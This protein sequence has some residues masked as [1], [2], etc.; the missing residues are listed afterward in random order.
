MAFSPSTFALM[1]DTL[2][3]TLIRLWTYG[4]RDSR[5]VV[6]SSAYVSGVSQRGV[7]VGDLV[8]VVEWDENNVHQSA[9]T[10]RVSAIIADSATLVYDDNYLQ[11]FSTLANFRAANIS[12]SIETVRVNGALTAGDCPPMTFV[13]KSSQPS[14]QGK[15]QSADGAWWE[16]AR[17]M[18]IDL[19]WFEPTTDDSYSAGDVTLAEA[20]AA[21]RTLYDA[22]SITIEEWLTSNTIA[23]KYWL[24]TAA[25]YGVKATAAPGLVRVFGTIVE[26]GN[27]FL[28]VECAAGLRFRS[29]PVTDR[30]D[31]RPM[32]NI[33]SNVGTALDRPNFEWRG[34][35]FLADGLPYG[36]PAGTP[37]NQGAGGARGG[38]LGF[39]RYRRGYLA[40]CHFK[41]GTSYFDAN[42]TYATPGYV[43]GDQ[44]VTF[45]QCK[46]I[47]MFD[48]HGDGLPDTMVYPRTNEDMDDPEADSAVGVI[49]ILSCS[50]K[51]CHKGVYGK[52]SGGRLIVRDFDAQ[53]CEHAVQA[54][55]DYNPAAA[56]GGT[57][58]QPYDCIISGVRGERIASRVIEVERAQVAAVSDVVVSDWG[59]RT[60]GEA[61]VT[62]GRSYVP[63]VMFTGCQ[64]FG[65]SNMHARLRDWDGG[66]STLHT[67][68]FL[69]GVLIES[70]TAGSGSNTIVSKT[71]ILSNISIEGI[72]IEVTAG[73][74]SEVV[75]TARRG[76][77]ALV[78]VR[79]ASEATVKIDG[80]MAPNVDAASQTF[81]FNSTV[82]QFVDGALVPSPEGSGWT[83]GAEF[84]FTATIAAGVIT[85][86]TQLRA[87][88]LTVSVDTQSAASSDDLDTISGAFAGQQITIRRE[89]ASHAVVLKNGTGNLSIG[90]DITLSA[91]DDF[92]V[93]SRRGN[94]WYLVYSNV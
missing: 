1:T 75:D 39:T 78:R 68:P 27:Y 82:A 45:I 29:V 24:E 37:W 85:I 59:R 74:A 90:A 49:E 65:L 94:T 54:L 22:D 71:G 6:T 38:C 17:G 44:G 67:A 30:A 50:A 7:R 87:Q 18:P 73:V 42:G 40:H 86:P 33:D 31:T 56:E 47:T 5:E 62:S 69:E 79:G 55:G 46:H 93:L 58:Y 19:L 8:L 15:Q 13:R 48:C 3:G 36:N 70:H 4:T 10:C 12:G 43:A 52:Y 84:T 64:N 76:T 66:D 61:N 20:W 2:G 11:E 35:R 80:W 60:D 23:V 9:Y 89:T 32:I 28:N 51:N 25:L 26:P 14:H 91:V 41:G 88:S 72:P 53:D 63:A 81:I 77:G 92:V 16:F 21:N 57:E 83:P 34:G